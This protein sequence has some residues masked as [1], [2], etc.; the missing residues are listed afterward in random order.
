[1]ET[2]RTE[3]TP[4]YTEKDFTFDELHFISDISYI[5]KAEAIN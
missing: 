2:D 3:P 5:P 4:F 1:M